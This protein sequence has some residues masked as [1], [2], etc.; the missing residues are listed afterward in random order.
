M[1]QASLHNEEDIHR[2]DVRIGD[3]VNIE[4]AGDVI[5]HVVG[6]VVDRRDGRETVFAM[7]SNCPVCGSEVV[8]PETEAMHRCPNTA[9]PAQFFE[10]LKHFVGKGAM[11]VDGLGEQWCRILIDEGLVSDVADLYFLQKEQL[12][13]LERMG[14]LLATKIVDNI[15]ASKARPLP[16]LVFAL[17]IIH[18]GS[19]IADLLVQRYADLDQLAEAAEEQL[20]EIPGI[21]PKIAESVAAY[22]R[23]P[24]NREVIDKLRQGGVQLHQEAAEAAAGPQ[25]LQGLT[26]RRYRDTGGVSPAGGRKPDQVAGRQRHVI[27]HPQDRLP[28]S[29]GVSGLQAGCGPAAGHHR[30]GR[31]GVPGVSG[32]GVRRAGRAVETQG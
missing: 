7:P 31:A 4:R 14:E 2:K 9:C 22:F 11:D 29:G 8:K 18:V 27:G 13:G 3:W 25:P 10:L 6:P 32:D 5:P 30:V 28:G 23:V 24:R 21:G 15:Q 20:T 12:L 16:R 19:E 26:F 1:K 17:G